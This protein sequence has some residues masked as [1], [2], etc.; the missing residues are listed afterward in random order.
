MTQRLIFVALGD[1][2]TFG[3]QSPS[4]TSLPTTT[5]YTTFL[6]EMIDKFFESINKNELEIEIHN[7]G[8]CGDLTG[9]M[10]NRFKHDV[11]KPDPDFVIVLGGSNDI[12]YNLPAPL[13][14]DNL[15]KIYQKSRENKIKPV[16]CTLPS[17]LGFDI[18]IKPLIELNNLIRKYC[19]EHNISCADLFLATSDRVTNRLLKKY[20]NDGLHL[21][22]KGYKKMAETIFND[23]LKT[24]LISE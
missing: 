16:A 9:G 3:Y 24:I 14:F 6:K 12:G 23:A 21:N 13:I 4:L 11:I 17:A 20:S 19:A 22:V 1:S 15:I 2:L 7:E 5:P 8:V 10:L 18:Y